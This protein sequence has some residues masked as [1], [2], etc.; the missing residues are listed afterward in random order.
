MKVLSKSAPVPVRA[1]VPWRWITLV[2][3]GLILLLLGG[4]MFARPGL[5]PTTG[6]LIAD[7]VQYDFGTVAI[8][9]GLLVTQ[10]PLMVEGT[11]RVTL[12]ESS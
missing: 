7:Q 8:G 2:M 5:A 9:D 3:G 4:A 10:L 12:L 1:A 6:T 11:V